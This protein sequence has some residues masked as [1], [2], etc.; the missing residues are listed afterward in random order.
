VEV[1]CSDRS[2]HQERVTTRECDIPG[3]PLQTWHD[4][5]KIEYAPWNRDHLSV[6]TAMMS[7]DE[8]INVALR[9]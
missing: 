1:L 5:V 3:Q 8:A 2:L 4:L 7:L 9:I 6:D